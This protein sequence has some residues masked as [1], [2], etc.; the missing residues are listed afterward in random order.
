[1][2]SERLHV[3][4]FSFARFNLNKEGERY[5]MD[6]TRNDPRLR[7]RLMC[8]KMYRTGQVQ[9]QRSMVVDVHRSPPPKAV[10]QFFVV[11]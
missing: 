9:R 3:K 11:D 7:F 10:G 5:C 1:M 4:S 6:E 8:A 2:G